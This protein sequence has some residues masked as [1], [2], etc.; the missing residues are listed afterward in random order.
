MFEHFPFIA[1]CPVCNTNNDGRCVMIPIQGT[2]EDRNSRAT[3]VHL[4]CAVPQWHDTERHM[5]YTAYESP[6]PQ[7]PQAAV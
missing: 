1:V 4:A 2:E 5:F 7:D 6:R 3:V